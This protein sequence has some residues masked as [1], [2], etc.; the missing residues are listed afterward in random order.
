MSMFNVGP[1]APEVVL[2]FIYF[3][4][5]LFSLTDFYYS[6]SKLDNLILCII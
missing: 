3:Y 6:F 5:F 1:E 2:I 4:L